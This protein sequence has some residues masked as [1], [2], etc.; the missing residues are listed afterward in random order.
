VIPKSIGTVPVQEEKNVAENN[1]AYLDYAAIAEKNLFHP[2]RKI[3]FQRGEDQPL[4]R[5]EIA[6][7]G[8]LITSEKR[9]AYIEDKKN[10]YSTPGRGKRQVAV[11][12]GGMIAGYKLVKVNAESIVLLRGEDKMV[13]TLDTQ[14]D[15]KPGETPSKL[16][17]P[18]QLPAVTRSSMSPSLQTQP[19][20]MPVKPVTGDPRDS[21][22]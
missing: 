17:A 15:R 4:T 12:E 16:Q 3:P 5:P 1:V 20:V 18:G 19:Q 7:F 21:R 10:P 11:T 8:T 14:K 9:I 13:I 6:L 22:R 2:E